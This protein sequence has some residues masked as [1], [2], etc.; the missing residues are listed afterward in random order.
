MPE[1]TRPASS[2]ALAFIQVHIDVGLAYTH[3]AL[4]PG[5]NSQ[6]VSRYCKYS[7]ESYENAIKLMDTMQITRRHARRFENDLAFLRL[8]LVRLGETL[9]ARDYP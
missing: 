1:L 4:K 9:G 5:R 2:Q 6:V 8:R 3:I 7:R